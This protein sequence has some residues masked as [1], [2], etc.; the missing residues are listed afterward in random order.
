MD[1]SLEGIGA[2]LSQRDGYTIVEEVVAG[3]AADREG[4]LEVKDRIIAVAQGRGAQ[5]VDVIDMA[6][7]DVVRLIRGKKGTE[8]QLTVLRKGAD[9]ATRTFAIVRDKIDLV[10]QAAQLRIETRTVEGRAV[11][12]ALIELPSFY[13]G[14]DKDNGR[15][16][17]R[18]VER[19]LAQ[20][21]REGAE[22]VIVDLSRNG[23]GLLEQAVAISGLFV[24]RGAVVAVQGRG[25]ERR[26]LEDEDEG[27]AWSGPLVVLTSRVSASASEILAGAVRDYR[28]GVIA[29]DARTFGKGTVQNVMNMPPGF[30]ALKV[31]T[32][33]YFRPGGDS[34]Q[35]SGVAADVVVP[36]GFDAEDVG[37][38]N[39]PNALPGRR[40]PAFLGG[41]VQAGAGQKPWKAVGDKTLGDL[42]RRSQERIAKNS[43]FA[44]I[45]EDL[46]K[47]KKQGGVVRVGDLLDEGPVATPAP[48]R[49]PRG[50][51][52]EKLTPQ[53]EEA[54]LVLA[55]L[56]AIERGSGGPA[57]Q[58]ADDGR[59]RR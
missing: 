8:V 25:G 54:L 52:E 37:E 41:S 30:G 38:G 23:G 21:A 9:P 27:I 15:Q 53:A 28:R 57:A 22:G 31:T 35:H 59:S 26:V 48:R 43:E 32:A 4:S 17:V 45:K 2:V 39:Y 51:G 33:M 58:L 13:G 11:K 55:D 40:V 16:S 12:L 10:D 36:S 49:R 44:K 42:A 34:T 29:G 19:L 24:R 7:R 6:L 56:V 5:A 50:A 3:G 46:E 14:Q 20:A 1:L 18:D 47:L